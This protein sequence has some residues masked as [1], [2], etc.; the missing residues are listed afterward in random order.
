MI[1]KKLKVAL[2]LLNAV[3]WSYDELISLMTET[4]PVILL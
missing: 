2:D 4:L 1:K 3:M